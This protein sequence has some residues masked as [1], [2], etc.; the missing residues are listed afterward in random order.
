MR[1]NAVAGAAALACMLAAGA[2]A[3]TPPDG[4]SVRGMLFDTGRK[5][6]VLVMTDAG[7]RFSGEEA[8]ILARAVAGMKYYGALAFSASGGLTTHVSAMAANFHGV[9]AARRVALAGCEEKR[10]EGDAP[11]D[12]V[13]VILPRDHV[14]GRP[15]TL[16]QDASAEFARKHRRARGA[17]AFAASES[18][19]HWGRADGEPDLAAAIA[20]AVAACEAKAQGA[21]DCRA[22][23]ADER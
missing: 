17:K 11:C 19:G 21:G 14:P 6:A 10:G 18:T 15:V 4:K 7:A 1:I 20:A 12:V 23:S 3:D 22:V 9:E 5:A 16:N 8:E 2:G 13:A